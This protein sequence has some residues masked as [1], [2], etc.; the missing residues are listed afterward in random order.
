MEDSKAYQ[1]IEELIAKRDDVI[2]TAEEKAKKVSEVDKESINKTKEK[3]VLILD[4]TIDQVK[5]AYE[6]NDDKLDKMINVFSIKASK[7]T[8]LAKN[9][10]SD[11]KE[12]DYYG[13]NFDKFLDDEKVKDL[14]EHKTLD[15]FIKG[16]KNVAI[17]SKDEVIKTSDKVSEYLNKPE[18]KEYKKKTFNFLGNLSK[19]VKHKIHDVNEKIAKKRSSVDYESF[20]EI[21]ID[22]RAEH[23]LQDLDNKVEE[24]KNKEL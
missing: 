3:L 11:F 22:K 4:D 8:E 1:F 5:T 12:K 6:N 17:F 16:A 21:E 20:D 7:A 2:K 14:D 23:I 18:V 10:F 24:I 13:Q 9:K 19:D 15:R